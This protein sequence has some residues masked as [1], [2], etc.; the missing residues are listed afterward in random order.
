MDSHESMKCGA[1]AITVCYGD[2]RHGTASG[3][4]PCRGHDVLQEHSRTVERTMRDGLS[5]SSCRNSKCATETFWPSCVSTGFARSGSR[6]RGII[7]RG[8]S[9]RGPPPRRLAPPSGEPT[10][11]SGS[12]RKCDGH[13]GGGD[14]TW[15]GVPAAVAAA[16]GP[17][18][19]AGAS[20]EGQ[21]STSV[22]VEDNTL[23]ELASAGR[24]A[25]WT[26][27]MYSSVAGLRS[28]CE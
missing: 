10:G 11:R 13:G 2:R 24:V 26:D 4:R 14:S 9:R 12:G 19:T 18:A 22:F 6:L 8:A 1:L 3:S 20:S 7:D 16:G 15:H 28:T 27:D 21:P 5:N 17:L 25:T 23:P